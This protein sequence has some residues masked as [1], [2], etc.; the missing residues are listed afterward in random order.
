MRIHRCSG[1]SPRRLAAG[2]ALAGVLWSAGPAYAQTAPVPSSK[3]EPSPKVDEPPVP[4]TG[5]LEGRVVRSDGKTPAAG[6]VVRICSL[7]T[8]SAV[9][10]AV[11]DTRGQFHVEG[12]A[13]GFFEIVILAGEEAFAANQVVQISPSERKTFDFVLVPSSETPVAA[14]GGAPRPSPCADRPPTGSAQVQ[15]RTGG[16][17]FFH[18][19]KGI[20][21]TAVA[22]AVALLLLTS[23]GGGNNETP[24][25]P[26]TP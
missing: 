22:G 26:S 14:S 18:T 6:A 19:K 4:G 15:S 20:A 3:P 8:D 7:E 13:Q 25:S 16:S 5:R 2:L 17:Q 11:A 9:G 10:S 1:V 23:G 24:A 12:L 21:I